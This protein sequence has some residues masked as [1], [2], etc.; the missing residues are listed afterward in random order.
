M[1]N[2]KL[3]Q[4]TNV[5]TDRNSRWH[6][7]S[8]RPRLFLP[9]RACE[10]GS[11]GLG[12]PSEG[13]TPAARTNFTQRTWVRTHTHTHTF[14][15]D[16]YRNKNVSKHIHKCIEVS[17]IKNDDIHCAVH[18]FRQAAHG[19]YHRGLQK[20]TQSYLAYCNKD[21]SWDAGQPAQ[22]RVT[23]NEKRQ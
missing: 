2:A 17:R 19:T 21:T 18:T 6:R 9:C 3:W 16:V 7:R 23:P 8:W 1:P 14:E 22:P 10:R 5:Q 20:G 4:T 15:H 12:T 13:Q 11:E